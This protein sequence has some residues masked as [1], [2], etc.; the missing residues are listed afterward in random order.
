[1]KLIFYSN[2]RFKIIPI[3][4]P[5]DVCVCMCVC[6]LISLSKHSYGNAKG[7]EQL[8]IFDKDELGGFA[9]LDIKTYFKTSV[10]KTAW[11]TNRE[12]G[13]PRNR[14][15]LNRTFDLLSSLHCREFTINDAGSAEQLPMKRN[16]TGTYLTPE[17]NMASKYESPNNKASRK[18]TQ[19]D[20]F[21]YPKVE[22]DISNQ[23]SRKET[24]KWDYI[25]LGSSAQRMLLRE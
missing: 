8:R 10:V 2:Y 16:K 6:N 17:A 4:I 3:K 7:K 20:I 18:I 15:I 22:R 13:E 12:K 11:Q 25:K 23:T 19:E 5:T 21:P 9:G 14:P 24:D 1:M